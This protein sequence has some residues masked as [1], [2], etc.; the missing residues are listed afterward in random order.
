[1]SPERIPNRGPRNRKLGFP[2]EVG[3]RGFGAG[4][5]H[6]GTGL[7]GCGFGLR[8]LGLPRSKILSTRC[9]P[10]NDQFLVKFDSN[11]SSSF[12]EDDLSVRVNG[13][14]SKGQKL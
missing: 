6:F 1:M 10:Q 13:E 2:K 14:R 12:T 11:W 7:R 5:R 8:A 9:P 4:L 3:L